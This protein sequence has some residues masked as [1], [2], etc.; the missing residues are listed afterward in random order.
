MIM[1]IIIMMMMMLMIMMMMNLSHCIYMVKIDI[2]LNVSFF[3]NTVPYVSNIDNVII[4]N[5][6]Q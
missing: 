3:D 1:L 4:N 6:F 5:F 2:Y